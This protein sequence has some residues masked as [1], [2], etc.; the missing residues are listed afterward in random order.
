RPRLGRDLLHPPPAG[1]A[2]GVRMDVVQPP[3]HGGRGARLGTR[4][5]SDGSRCLRGENGG[6]RRR[7]RRA[8]DA[9]G[10]NDE[11]PLRPRRHGDARGATR[12][13]GAAAGDRDEDGRLPRGGRG[14]RGEAPAELQRELRRDSTSPSSGQRPSRSF[15]KTVTP[16]ATTSYWLFAPSRA[17]A[18]NPCS[19]SS[20][21]R[22]AARRS[23]PL[24]TG[25]Y[26][27][28]TVIG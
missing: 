26:R 4:V 27:I 12:A 15:E 24:Q 11:A 8:A 21:A 5:G 23:Y 3:P 7:V 2:T 13:R 25:Q 18:S 28:S 17:A 20:A 6:A 19:R 14:V 16:S 22:L 9:R 10:R 1:R